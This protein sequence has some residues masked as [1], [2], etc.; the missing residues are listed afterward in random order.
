M[1][2]GNYTLCNFYSLQKTR[3]SHGSYKEVDAVVSGIQNPKVCEALH[4][5]KMR[6]FLNSV[7][8]ENDK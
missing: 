6:E 3:L 8:K 4:F 1:R 2:L 7:K 5:G